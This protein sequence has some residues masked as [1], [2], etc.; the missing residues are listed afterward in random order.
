MLNSTFH[1]SP[2]FNL[3]SSFAV[4][5]DLLYD[6]MEKTKSMLDEYHN[7]DIKYPDLRSLLCASN[8]VVSPGDYSSSLLFQFFELSNHSY[9]PDPL[10][11]SYNHLECKCF[12]GLFPE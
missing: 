6:T 3:P 11:E 4:P 12:M 8:N 7:N 2:D 10:V 5:A 9:L 1:N